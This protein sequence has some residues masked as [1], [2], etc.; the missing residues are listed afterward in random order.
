MLESMATSTNLK[1][2]HTYISRTKN[3]EKNTSRGF[4]LDFTVIV[5]LYYF[6]QFYKDTALFT[7]RPLVVRFELQCGPEVARQ[8]Q[9]S[10]CSLQ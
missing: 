1:F 2:S 10:L 8:K 4:F 3:G 6:Q 9:D 5:S 7:I